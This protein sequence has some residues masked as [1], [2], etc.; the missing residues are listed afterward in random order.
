MAINRNK[1]LEAAQK[2]QRKGNLDKAILEYRKLV[3]DDPGDMRSMIKVADLY[4]RQGKTDAALESYKTIAYHYLNDDIYD[5]ASAFFKQAIRL[6]NQDPKLYRDLGEAY[7]RMGRLKEAVGQYH[8]A[9]RIYEGKRDVAAQRDILE[10]MVRLE[11]EEPALRIKL[12]E[13]YIKAGMREEAV[14]LFR[15]AAQQ[16]ED[17]GRLDDYIKVSERIIYLKSSD[18]ELRKK[19]LDLYLDNQDFKKALKHLQVLFQQTPTD[20][21]ILRKLSICFERLGQHDKLVLVLSE[22]AR[23]YGDQ[24]DTQR[25]LD[26]YRKV[27][28]HSPNHKDAKARVAYYEQR[29]RQTAQPQ[30]PQARPQ[31]KPQHARP[32]PQQPA[33]NVADIEFLDDDLE[34]VLAPSRPQQ[35][36]QPAHA[37]SRQPQTQHAQPRAPQPRQPQP[38][39]RQQPQPQQ[40]PQQLHGGDDL[41]SFAEGALSEFEDIGIDDL[42]IQQYP[43]Q[44]SPPAA[45]SSPSWAPPG[46]QPSQQ[47]APQQYVQPVPVQPEPVLIEPEPIEVHEIEYEP[48]VAK[49]DEDKELRIAID[50]ARV[51][52][53]YGLVDKAVA[54]MHDT[55]KRFPHSIEAREELAGFYV[56]QGQ[57]VLAADQFIEIAK[58]VKATPQRAAQYLE[59]AASLLG[60]RASV[61]AVAQQL[62][63]PF[64]QQLDVATDDLVELDVLS[65]ATMDIESEVVELLDDDDLLLVDA[66]SF[67]SGGFSMDTGTLGDGL[68]LDTDDIINDDELIELDDVDLVDLDD[69]GGVSNGALPEVV[70]ERSFAISPPTRS[71]NVSALN[72]N[73]RGGGS[74][75]A[76]GLTEDEADAM[77]D[78]LFGD[79]N[80]SPLTM[81]FSGSQDLAGIAEVDFLIEQGLMSEAEDALDSLEQHNPKSA[82]IQRRRLN[83]ENMRTGA[84][85]NPFGSRSLSKH[86]AFN[87]VDD[88]LETP[89]SP[90]VADSVPSII[91]AGVNA[92]N[93]NF[94]LGAAY[95]EM[96]L[97]QEAIEEF[98]Q[99]L[100]DPDVADGAAYNIAMCEMKLGKVDDARRR[101][102]TLLARPTTSN[103]VR[104]SAQQ[105]LQRMG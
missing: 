57:S 100:D 66:D 98:Q 49:V 70:Q 87:S 12:A 22:Q 15:Y 86:F 40:P 92:V 1:V 63:I 102:Q 71:K 20:L 81:S 50:E 26:L 36:S 78:D 79:S 97:F 27:L 74:N 43:G 58:V 47:P 31:T 48:E 39:P 7:H 35:P 37:F 3:E 62:G 88:M 77:F 2:H 16:F 75:D 4:A 18:F 29:Q 51:F 14:G 84:G 80:A 33:N 19:I 55:L 65:P 9:Q 93:T 83:L 23:I 34:D 85:P 24:G 67:D 60:S 61:E 6:N 69:L 95:M 73:P 64:G 5:K 30:Q 28:Q 103:D 17:D 99:S 82:T 44:Q 94:E 101:L 104:H 53:K 54:A 25:S 90:A 68:D 45:S 42:N 21:E 105:V 13:F 96:G 38:Q 89:R 59:S 8:L 41:F 46:Q 56:K 11:P 91:G 52:V 72:I 10:R 32:Q 76:F